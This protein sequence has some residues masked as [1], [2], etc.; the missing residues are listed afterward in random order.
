LEENKAVFDLKIEHDLTNAFP[1]GA[2]IVNRKLFERL[3]L[4]DDKMFVGFEDYELC[5]RGMLSESP[6]K[7]RLINNVELLHIHRYL[8]EN[9]DKKTTLTRYN[10]GFIEKSSERIKEKH[11]IIL[12]S[13]WKK[14]VPQQIENILK[15]KIPL[16]EIRDI[17][18]RQL[19]IAIGSAFG[20]SKEANQ[21][22]FA[23]KKY[24]EYRVKEVP[25]K[26]GRIF[27]SKGNWTKSI[28]KKLANKVGLNYCDV[29]HSHENPW[30]VNL[31]N[32]SKK[33]NNKW[34][35]T[36]HSFYFEDD[37]PEGLKPWQKKINRNLI[38]IAS[39]ADVKI[40]TSK[41]LHSYLFERYS[42]GT[43]IIPN[44]VDLESCNKANPEK[45]M[46]K[47]GL[48]DFIL[49][50]GNIDQIKKPQVFVKLAAQIPD[51]KFL[52]LGQDINKINLIKFYDLQLPEN[53]FFISKISREEILDAVSA[54]KL[55]I[56]TSK[57]E[58]S[59]VTLLEAM[60][61][62]KTVVAPAHSGCKE[63]IESNNYGYLY[64]P[65]SFEDL[66]SKTKEALSSEEVGEKA[67][68][69]VKINYDWNIL[70]KKIDLLYEA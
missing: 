7:A 67:R 2:S 54:C 38:D 49:F 48:R 37:H 4:Y 41:W 9:E 59:P 63:V 31:C 20:D 64:E 68:E 53:L 69:R 58:G 19:R 25:S 5:I 1:G 62:G 24:S 14:W 17:H 65:E 42:I 16:R 52:M 6:V 45:F 66:V 8:K 35:H 23:V 34:I 43:E 39:K 21:Y 70:I 60:G 3:S 57:R 30:F 28:Y 40:S 15:D 56:M 27:T 26:F 18:E 32:L 51:I 50:V 61:M 10:T 11:N 46:K 36:Y 55:F 13:G 44:G 29:L 47:F 22:V 12:I 33:N